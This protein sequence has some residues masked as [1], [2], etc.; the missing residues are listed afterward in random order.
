LG[1]K[2]PMALFFQSLRGGRLDLG[3]DVGASMGGG[4]FGAGNVGLTV[5]A[6]RATRAW[7]LRA[8][9]RC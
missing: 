6:R 5:V 1:M 2:G 3:G 9:Q 7:R 4:V 8:R